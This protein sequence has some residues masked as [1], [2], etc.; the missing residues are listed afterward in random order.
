M[1]QLLRVFPS[2][3][4]DD[5]GR[6]L[7]EKN[8]KTIINLLQTN[9][10]NIRNA[11]INGFDISSGDTYNA[12][13]NSLVVT[14]GQSIF[15][16]Y[17][18]EAI[19]SSYTVKFPSTT[20]LPSSGETAC[21]YLCLHLKYTTGNDAIKDYVVYDGYEDFNLVASDL[22]S[23]NIYTATSQSDGDD[24]PFIII[25]YN[26]EE[27]YGLD[28]VLQNLGTGTDGIEEAYN[29]EYQILYAITLTNESGSY[30]MH[31]DDRRN[32]DFQPLHE[33]TIGYLANDADETEVVNTYYGFSNVEKLDDW[34]RKYVISKGGNTEPSFEKMLY[35]YITFIHEEIRGYKGETYALSL[36]SPDNINP[37]RLVRW[38]NK[39]GGTDVSETAPAQDTL[40][41]GAYLPIQNT[42][43]YRSSIIGH[44]SFAPNEIVDNNSFDNLPVGDKYINQMIVRHT[45][46]HNDV[47]GHVSDYDAGEYEYEL[48][49]GTVAPEQI[50]YGTDYLVTL[51]DD[52]Q[53]SRVFLP[54]SEETI[55]D[56]LGRTGLLSID[57]TYHPGESATDIQTGDDNPSEENSDF[58]QRL[59]EYDTHGLVKCYASRFG[60]AYILAD[61]DSSGSM[62]TS[63]PLV[64]NNVQLDLIGSKNRQGLDVILTTLTQETN[65]S[66]NQLRVTFTNP[67]PVN[68]AYCIFY[69]DTIEDTDYEDGEYTIN[70]H[71]R[72][73]DSPS[74]KNMTLTGDVDAPSVLTVDTLVPYSGDRVTIG[75]DAAGGGANLVV[76]GTIN[77]DKV[78]SAVYND[79]AELF[80]KADIS[81]T[82]EV[83]DV[84]AK[85][86]DKEGYELAQPTYKKNIVGVYSDTYGHL[87]GGDEN[88][89]LEENLQTHIP[90][91]LCGRVKVKVVGK[92]AIGD[93]LT[94][95]DIPGVAKATSIYAPGE[96]IGKAIEHKTT[97]PEGLVNMM[98]ML[99]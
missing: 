11:V 56:E 19:N 36:L 6:I 60:F 43:T 71:L 3:L 77:A 48:S 78:Y 40:N 41:I 87:L 45:G 23:G 85:S 62:A 2:N 30:T 57:V 89:T 61:E 4:A 95:S 53:I 97:Q 15:R 26:G 34:H 99:G 44:L 1:S 94:L 75:T 21:Y 64:N 81:E 84:I 72:T 17:Q 91:G 55:G 93:Y 79:Y 67:N 86:V 80:K 58:F 92:V 76:N 33:M 50:A 73:S 70:Q 65:D 13:N 66:H 63:L 25:Q 88:A 20:T 7:T 83:G 12:S 16:G 42:Q 47:R 46:V 24:S 59:F 68:N 31:V 52:F 9:N 90:I 37:D 74:F 10:N 69:D 98:I 8:I 32:R 18:V 38:D 29:Y 54:I 35:E 28:V 82:F 22:G 27:P 49:T 14:G 96:I 5:W 51:N 39:W